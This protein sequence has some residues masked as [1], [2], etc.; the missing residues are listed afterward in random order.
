MALQSEEEIAVQEEGDIRNHTNGTAVISNS[1]FYGNSTATIGGGIYI[2]DAGHVT[3]ANNTMSNNTALSNGS[4]AGLGIF[5]SG[6]QSIA[7]L[8][9]KINN[10]IGTGVWINTPGFVNLLNNEIVGNRCLYPQCADAG[11]VKIAADEIIFDHN[12]VCE[13]QTRAGAGGIMFWANNLQIQSFSVELSNNVICN[14]S[15]IDGGIHWRTRYPRLCD[16]N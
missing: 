4:G 16:H 15:A 1:I 8:D 12:T 6:T 11:S 7:I 2:T 14:N 13:N 5:G 10:N 9:N 3:L